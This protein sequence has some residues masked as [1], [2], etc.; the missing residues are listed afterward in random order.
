MCAVSV[1]TA[2]LSDDPFRLA[3]VAL[4]VASARAVQ[5]SLYRPMLSILR[6]FVLFSHNLCSKRDM[7]STPFVDCICEK[8]ENY[9]T[10]RSL[11]FWDEIC[12][13]HLMHV[14][15]CDNGL[16][17]LYLIFHSIC[18]LHRSHTSHTFSE[19]IFFI[20]GVLSCK[21]FLNANVFLC[22]CGRFRVRPAPRRC[23][24]I[25]PNFVYFFFRIC[26]IEV[27]TRT[28]VEK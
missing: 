24:L 23:E 15:A 13:T 9:L 26:L 10:I 18:A 17:F 5:Y 25:V 7:P 6:K 27:C 20:C 11:L 19:L 16:Y 22:F 28:Q 3:I 8:C 12:C 1:P 2:I 14:F 21:S 4:P